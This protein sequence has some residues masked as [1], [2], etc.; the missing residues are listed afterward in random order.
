MAGPRRGLRDV[1]TMSDL[2]SETSNP[3]RKYLKLAMLAM[4]KTR[5]GKE[6]QS[7]RLRIEDIDGRLA[8][9]EAKIQERGKRWEIFE[10]LTGF[11][12]SGRISDIEAF[13]SLAPQLVEE[14]RTGKYEPEVLRRFILDG[15]TGGTLQSL[16]C[17]SCGARFV[18]D[19][20]PKS[21]SDYHCPLTLCSLSIYVRVDRDASQRARGV[22]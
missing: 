8:E 7:A 2:L 4:E 9:I 12:G 20:P 21:Y 5:R 14:A 18:V 15:L 3:Q 1:R 19:K 6:R 22:Q 13:V 16:V 17:T 11:L 10:S